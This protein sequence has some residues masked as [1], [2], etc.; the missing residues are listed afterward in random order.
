MEKLQGHSVGEIPIFMLCLAKIKWVI[1]TSSICGCI[2]LVCC[3]VE[4]T[5]AYY[6]LENLAK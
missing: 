3:T 5:H 6:T 1:L 2:S 4:D